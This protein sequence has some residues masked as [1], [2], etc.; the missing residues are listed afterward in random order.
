MFVAG[1]EDLDKVFQ[2]PNNTFIG[3]KE[4]VLTLREIV[5]R[6][7]VRQLWLVLSNELR[8]GVNRPFAT[9]SRA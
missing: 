2:L 6:L 9:M 5:D 1:V 3:G 4:V 8:T 7:K